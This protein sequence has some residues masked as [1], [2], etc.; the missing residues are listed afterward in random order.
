M[1]DINTQTTASLS[2]RSVEELLKLANNFGKQLSDLS[3]SL[4]LWR[5]STVTSLAVGIL[6][7]IAAVSSNHPD[8]KAFAILVT[9]AA[10]LVFVY[11]VIRWSSISGQISN[12]SFL[13][14]RAIELISSTH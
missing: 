5:I 6:T 11:S 2:I 8:E 9:S 10:A 4:W 7:A 14:E 1:V 13:H 12:V 3:G